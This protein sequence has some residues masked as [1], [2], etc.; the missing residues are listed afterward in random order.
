LSVQ[1][2]VKGVWKVI[3]HTDNIALINATFKVSEAGRQRTI[4][5]RRK[6]VHAFVEGVVALPNFETNTVS[7]ITYNPYKNSSFINT[8]TFEPIEQAKMVIVQNTHGMLAYN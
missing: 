5:R 2:K 3:G 7:K 1:T 6:T 4:T 8:E